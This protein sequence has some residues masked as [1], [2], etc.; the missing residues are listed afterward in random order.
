MRQPRDEVFFLEEREIRIQARRDVIGQCP[1]KLL[2]EVGQMKLI[3]DERVP[4]Q[5]GK[6]IRCKADHS[7]EPRA[8]CTNYPRSQTRIARDDDGLK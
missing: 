4:F 3:E 8:F 1:R 5:D 2:V 6:S 7:M